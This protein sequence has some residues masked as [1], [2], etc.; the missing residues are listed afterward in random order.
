M[1]RDLQYASILKFFVR[2]S[3]LVHHSPPNPLAQ[4]LQVFF[5]GDLRYDLQAK[6]LEL[7]VPEARVD[8][9]GGK[10]KDQTTDLT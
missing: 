2:S 3:C 6:R 9:N 10:F 4:T 8:F 7:Q 5:Q 1:K